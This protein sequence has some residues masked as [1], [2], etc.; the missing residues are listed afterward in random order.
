[1]RFDAK[2]ELQERFKQPVNQK[3]KGL[4]DIDSAVPIYQSFRTTHDTF[5]APDEEQLKMFQE[6]IKNHIRKQVTDNLNESKYEAALEASSDL[7]S[8]KEIVAK[9][10]VL[11]QICKTDKFDPDITYQISIPSDE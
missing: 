10:V 2:K 11:N 7:Q 5:T 1:M 6:T 8:S 9:G 4:P 3:P